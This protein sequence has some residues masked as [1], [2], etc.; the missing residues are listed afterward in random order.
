MAKSRV[1]EPLE[2]TEPP[3]KKGY[4]L[5]VKTLAK[6]LTFLVIIYVGSILAT[7]FIL[8][9]NEIKQEPAK[10]TVPNTFS[11]RLYITFSHTSHSCL[12]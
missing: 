3:Q 12:Q 7:Y 2:M 6:I 1:V 8:K 9:P 10:V 5:T 11:I 4:F